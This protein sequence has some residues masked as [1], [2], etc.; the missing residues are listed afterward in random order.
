M[1]I[2]TITQRRRRRRRH[3][4]EDGDVDNPQH[5]RR[6]ELAGVDDEDEGVDDHAQH[7]DAVD[8]RVADATTTGV[9]PDQQEWTVLEWTVPQKRTME[10][11]RT[12]RTTRTVSET[13]PG[14]PFRTVSRYRTTRP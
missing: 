12:R 9:T 4:H 3:D 11:T 5:N 13:E 7:D 14:G 1:T 6:S 2:M 8:D 10:R